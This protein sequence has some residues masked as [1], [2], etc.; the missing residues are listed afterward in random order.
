MYADNTLTP[1]EAIRLCAL[2]LLAAGPKPYDE[3]VFAVRHFVSRMTGPSLDLMGESIEL[4]RYE[5]LIAGDD[6]KPLAITDE[7]RAV[8]NELLRANVR[9]GSGAMNDLVIALKIRFL[10]LLP[11]HEQREQAEL[12][13]EACESELARI[14][15]VTVD[16]SGYLGDW[17]AIETD[18]L[19]AR[20]GYLR[21]ML[22]ANDRHQDIA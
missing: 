16:E 14:E 21:H 12:V 18:R 20:I 6:G 22:T 15:D 3:V 5:G 13:I 1:R 11:P 2:G 10:H 17:L 8:L 19:N 9:A 4:L 7:G